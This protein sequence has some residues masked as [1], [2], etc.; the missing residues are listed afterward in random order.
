MALRH[1]AATAW[2]SCATAGSGSDVPLHG[3]H[4]GAL[5]GPSLGCGALRR[6][7]RIT[8]PPLQRLRPGSV[9]PRS[10]DPRGDPDLPI[11][12]SSQIRVTRQN[13]LRNAS[14]RARCATPIAA[15]IRW[16]SARCRCR[17]E[18]RLGCDTSGS[19]PVGTLGE[20][21][22][23]RSDGVGAPLRRSRRS[24]PQALDEDADGVREGGVEV[25]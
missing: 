24:A 9:P 25:G 2:R 5:A 15:R 21:R 1:P 4:Y 12:G 8:S 19:P 23:R 10:V 6:E 11:R 16:R 7:P 3:C 17:P 20:A 13:A 14:L 18:R 22:T